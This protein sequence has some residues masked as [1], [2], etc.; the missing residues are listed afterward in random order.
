MG[1]LWRLRAARR[2]YLVSWLAYLGLIALRTPAP[3]AGPAEAMQLLMALNGGAI[4]ALAWI[5]DL[6]G[7]FVSLAQAFGGPTA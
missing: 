5:S 7:R 6:R 2:L 4:L 3:A 1:L